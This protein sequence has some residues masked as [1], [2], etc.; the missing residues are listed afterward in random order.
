MLPRPAWAIPLGVAVFLLWSLWLA[1]PFFGYGSRSYVAA[2]DTGDGTLPAKLWL[3]QTPPAPLGLWDPKGEAGT[4]R[5]A[6]GLNRDQDS[7]LFLFLP[8]WLAYGLFMWLQRFIAGYFTYRL[9]R[10]AFG[11]D[12]LAAGA[13]GAA[14]ALFT[15]GAFGDGSWQGFALFDGLALPALPL[16]LWI[17]LLTDRLRLGWALAVGA[18]TGLLY[19]Y[20]SHFF[21]S[22]FVVPLVCVV[23]LFI[24]PHRRRLP[25]APL[26]SFVAFWLA[27]EGATLWAAAANTP[28]SQR[29]DWGA[30]RAG[31]GVWSVYWPLVRR[32]ATDN[33]PALCATGLALVV[34]AVRRAWRVLAL[35]ALT[36]A[37]LGLYLV[38]GPLREALSGPLP[39]LSGFRFDRAY[40]VLPFLAVLAGGAGAALLPK[41]AGPWRRAGRP[42]KLWLPLQPLVGLAVLGVVVP[43]AVAMQRDMARERRQGIT[44]AAFYQRR[45][46]AAV[47][48]ER[49]ADRPFRVVSVYAAPL[50]A[51]A[52][53]LW[54]PAFAW[55]YGLETADGYTVMYSKRY[56]EYWAE[57]LVTNAKGSS[58]LRDYFEH[59]GSH[60][61]LYA[62]NN[63]LRRPQ[64]LVF[65]TR[66]RLPLLSLANVRYVIS[67]VRL[68][69]A[70]LAPLELDAG[71]RLV[72]QP[73]GGIGSLARPAQAQA[74]G[75][76]L[77]IYE[78]RE[79]LPRAFAV[80]KARLFDDEA[81][82]RR[83]LHGADTAELA[84][85]A[86]VVRDEAR[87]AVPSSMLSD[88]PVGHGGVSPPSATLV[89][90]SADEVRVRVEATAPS[91]L[92]FTVEYSRFWRAWVDGRR[93]TVVP[94]DLAFCGVPCGA[95]GHEVVLR[96]QP[97][98]RF[99]P[100]P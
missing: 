21:L 1:F 37:D 36:A 99:W 74:G 35:V 54:R 13:L 71:G 82:V 84:S 100:S 3:R 5:L 94:V 65:A 43:Q 51:D 80:A 41:G 76:P 81:A 67:P 68:R 44:Y 4:D 48:A 73:G 30:G 31:T 63:G 58:A 47:R 64:G 28:L 98:Y 91:L 93:A 62:P 15:Q 87:D 42:R 39:L 52:P 17:V 59:H 46:I 60:V 57:L 8:G 75:H 97:P 24:L 66:W 22:V 50:Y 70:A 11:T 77:Y 32:L 16:L 88:I 18:V 10:D 55:A 92:L 9:L 78:N 89:R 19:A 61:Y 2:H 34:A 6:E 20:A 12:A 23:G 40:V 29:G 25:W 7:V 72:P 85:T 33:L 45:D 86:F 27:G 53:A 79:M 95:G 96:Y 90:Y 69:D 49:R 38:S 56:Q 26:L 83:A 14:Y